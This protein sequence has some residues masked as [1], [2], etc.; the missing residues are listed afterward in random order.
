M[1]ETAYRL[2]KT[3]Y[4]T[5]ALTGEG[6]ERFGGRWNPR[7]YRCVYTSETLALATLELLVHL[8]G[9][10]PPKLSYIKLTLLPAEIE[11]LALAKLPSTWATPAQ[12]ALTQSIGKQWLAAQRTLALRVP[13]AIIPGEHN[14]LINPLHPKFAKLGVSTAQKF[15]IDQRLT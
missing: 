13:S 7:G 9:V 5:S 2:F 8:E 12:L 11:T 15:S 10:P 3:K 4:A 14:L 6:A 1:S